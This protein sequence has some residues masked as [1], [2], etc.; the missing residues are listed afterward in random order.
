[1][2][3][4]DFELVAEEVRSPFGEGADDGQ[5]FFLMDGVVKLG[6]FEGSR[7]VSNRSCEIVRWSKGQD[8]S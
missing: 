4:P 7:V 2:I 3:C 6:T 1:M 5:L 8:G